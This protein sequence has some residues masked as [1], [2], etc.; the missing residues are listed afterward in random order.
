MEQTNNTIIKEKSTLSSR[1]GDAIFCALV[2]LYPVVQFCIFYI[3]VNISSIAL[4]FQEQF[5]GQMIFAGFYQFTQVFNNFS[6]ES[7]LIYSA[8][9][10]IIAYL[11]GLVISEPLA[12]IFSF[13][14]YKKVAGYKFF[15]VILFLPSIIS[16][17]VLVL[18]YKY[19]V[20]NIIPDIWQMIFGTKINL[21][22]PATTEFW[23]ILFFSVFIGCGGR[24]L[25]Y[26]STMGGINESIVESAQLDGVSYLGELWHIT[27]PS[28]YPTL[29]TFIVAGIATIF[30]NELSIFSF[31]GT[32]ASYKIYTFGYYIYRNVQLSADGSKFPYLSALG[33]FLSMIAIPVTLLVKKGMEKFGPS[34]E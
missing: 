15:R 13:S 20:I 19:F 9:N 1:K 6:Q 31:E 23:S 30:T 34:A 32:E 5:N 11:V 12:I 7:S 22:D 28:I 8:I 27:L 21:M 18:I 2:L 24:T 29:V 4:A 10:S 17:L 14:I 3:Y 25:M 16:S 33:L 26:T